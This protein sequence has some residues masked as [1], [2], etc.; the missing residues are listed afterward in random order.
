MRVKRNV[1][2]NARLAAT[3]RHVL[4]GIKCSQ[5]LLDQSVRKFQVAFVIRLVSRAFAI[6]NP[7]R[8]AV[9]AILW[10]LRL[11]IGHWRTGRG[12]TGLTGIAAIGG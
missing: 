2:L 11:G 4:T 5:Q 3:I 8:S 9:G 10:L 12:W 6:I 7:K 1:Q